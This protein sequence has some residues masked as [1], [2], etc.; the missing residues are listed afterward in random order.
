MR[1]YRSTLVSLK[2]DA[3]YK[4]LT[5]APFDRLLVSVRYQ[6]D[7]LDRDDLSATS[8]SCKLRFCDAEKSKDFCRR[9][10]S[11]ADHVLLLCLR[12]NYR[13][14]WPQSSTKLCEREWRSALQGP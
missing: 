4:G 5:R 8:S 3:V 6:N 12:W 1:E 10:P 11:G 2:I 7:D 13:H 14:S 9:D